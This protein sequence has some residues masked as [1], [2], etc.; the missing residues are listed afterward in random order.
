[1]LRRALF[2]LP[3]LAVS[4][5]APAQ[6]QN[7]DTRFNFHNRS[8]RTVTEI[9]FDR[10][11]NP[12]WTR[13][14]L[15]ADVLPAGRSRTFRAAYSGLYDFKAVLETGQSVELRQVDICRITDVT[16]TDRGMSAQ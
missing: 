4:A 11:S 2:A 15:G 5:L 1:M 16:V 3:L 13:D 10:S 12:N 14:E 6:A 8:S 9:Y 7:C